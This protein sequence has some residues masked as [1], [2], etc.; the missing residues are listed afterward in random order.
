MGES[1]SVAH[2]NIVREYLENK[3]AKLIK[4]H[5]RYG[6]SSSC[7][8]WRFNWWHRTVPWKKRGD[9]WTILAM[10]TPS[11]AII[12][13]LFHYCELWE[14]LTINL[15]RSS[16]WLGIFVSAT[17]GNHAQ[18]C[19]SVAEAGNVEQPNLFI[20]MSNYM[21]NRLKPFE[22]I[23]NQSKTK[24]IKVHCRYHCRYGSSCFH[25]WSLGR[26]NWWHRT[27]PWKKRGDTWKNMA[28]PGHDDA[29]SFAIVWHLFYDLRLSD[30]RSTCLVSLCLGACFNNILQ[31]YPEVLQKRETATESLQNYMSNSIGTIQSIRSQNQSRSTADTAAAASAAGVTGDATRGITPFLGRSGAVTLG[32]TIK[33]LRSSVCLGICF[34]IFHDF[35]IPRSFAE[36]KAPVPFPAESFSSRGGFG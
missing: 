19:C 33:L 11:S 4:V 26:F 24:S 35:S 25:C 27:V 9:T 31:P 1:E 34:N 7:F 29:I 12:W 28:Y 30:W 3:S 16:V 8:H 18:K 13:H 36:A 6:S 14:F 21:G 17:S 32:M 22:N 5:C 23:W 15:F 10:I 2:R 20:C